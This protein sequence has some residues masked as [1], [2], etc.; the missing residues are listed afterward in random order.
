MNKLNIISIFCV[1]FP[2][3]QEKTV[4]FAWYNKDVV[5]THIFNTKK[6]RILSL[7]R[8]AANKEDATSINA[9]VLQIFKVDR[10]ASDN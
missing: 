10:V 3:Q 5:N 2:V 8:T 6:G 1:K 7:A 9:T 4:K